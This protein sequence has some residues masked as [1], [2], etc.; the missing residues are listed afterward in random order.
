MKNYYDE[1][2]VSRFASKEV[3]EKAYKVLAK[4]YH[5]D[6]V[7]ADKKQEAEEHFKKISAAYEVLSNDVKKANYD[8]QL[9][10]SQP[11]IS[12][13]EYNNLIKTNKNLQSELSVL[14]NKVQTLKNNSSSINSQPTTSTNYQNYYQTSNTNNKLLSKFKEKIAYALAVIKYKITNFFK[15]IL[16]I[17]LTILLIYIIF[18]IL[19]L[20]PYTRSILLDDMGIKLL[21]NFFN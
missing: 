21:L 17:I 6:M 10:Q 14:K 16:A 12:T 7:S 18:K 4:K 19:L 8:A 5:P 13:E 2:E 9:N 15:T 1:L 11:N 20:I 3:I